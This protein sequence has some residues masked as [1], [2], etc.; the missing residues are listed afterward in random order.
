MSIVVAVL[1]LVIVLALVVAPGLVGTA[2][3]LDRLHV[4]TDAAW[5]ALDAALARRAVV[6]RAVSAA[7]LSEDQRSADTLRAVAERAEQAARIDREA[8]ENDLTLQIG[9][10]SCRERV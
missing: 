10:A 4:R 5:A 6:A 7:G 3:R 9:R 8:A 2:S 1:V